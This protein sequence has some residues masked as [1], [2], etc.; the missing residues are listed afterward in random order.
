[1]LDPSLSANAV[2]HF[3]EFFRDLTPEKFETLDAEA[4]EDY[5]AACWAAFHSFDDPWWWD[6]FDELSDFAKLALNAAYWAW[7]GREE[8]QRQIDLS[9]LAE[10]PPVIPKGGQVH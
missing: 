1:M 6:G 8:T 4:L 5:D 10:I 9:Q 3:R 7:P 2:D